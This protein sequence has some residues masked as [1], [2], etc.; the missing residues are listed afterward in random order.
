MTCCSLPG[1]KSS[2]FVVFNLFD[3]VWATISLR[4]KEEQG[5]LK[6][7]KRAILTKSFMLPKSRAVA[8][9]CL[10][11]DHPTIYSRSSSPQPPQNFLLPSSPSLVHPLPPRTSL[12]PTRSPSVADPLR[13][14]DSKS[15]SISNHSQSTCTSLPPVILV[16]SLLVHRRSRGQENIK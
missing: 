11:L 1:I 14:R 10:L 5:G 3:A 4:Y 13:N 16:W 15:T 9:C 8:S 2:F 12:R 7:A 6:I